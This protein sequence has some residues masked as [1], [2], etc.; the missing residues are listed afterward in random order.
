MYT[1]DKNKVFYIYSV[2]THYAKVIL[3][4]AIKLV[5]VTRRHVCDLSKDFCTK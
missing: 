3:G 1:T 4:V 2:R 5:I